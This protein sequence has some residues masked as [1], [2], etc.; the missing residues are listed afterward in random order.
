M[1]NCQYRGYLYTPIH[2]YAPINPC[3]P[4]YPLYICMYVTP[5][6][7]I[8][9]MSW[10]LGGICTSVRPFCVYP[11]IHPVACQFITVIPVAPHH[12]GL[13]SLGLDAY[14]CMLCFMLLTCS[15]L[16]SVF[17]MSQASITKATTTTP[18]VTVVSPLCYLFSQ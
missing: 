11:S 3:A 10:A 12:C 13:P 18:L 15:F 5:I 14:G 7:Y 2:L 6:P 4:P 1:G 9:H 17:I 16:C 8:P